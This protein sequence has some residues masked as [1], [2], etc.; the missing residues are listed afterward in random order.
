MISL[1]KIKEGVF[2]E[3]NMYEENL[4]NPLEKIVIHIADYHQSLNGIDSLLF[5]EDNLVKLKRL[6]NLPNGII[7]I[8][9]STSA[10]KT[11][12]MYSLLKELDTKAKNIITV[13]DP[14]KMR[15]EGI[16]QVEVAPEKGLTM[17]SILRSLLVQDPNVICLSEINNEEI[18]FAFNANVGIV[19]TLEILNTCLTSAFPIITS[20]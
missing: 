6:I 15:I 18:K 12:T 9:G 1:L 10:G 8:C 14:V 16:N 17:S 13:E 19:P 11:T 5:S 7:L 3:Q 2:M 4:K 20:L